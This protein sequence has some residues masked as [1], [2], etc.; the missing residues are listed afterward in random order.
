[1][2]DEIDVVGLAGSPFIDGWLES[3]AVR[4]AKPE[5]FEH[6]DFVWIGGGLGRVD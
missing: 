3:E 6:F 4:A 2:A 5:V 1:M